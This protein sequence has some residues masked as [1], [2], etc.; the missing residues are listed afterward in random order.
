MTRNAK[1]SDAEEDSK[2][3][4]TN[5]SKQFLIF[6]PPMV[7]TLHLKRFQQTLMGCRKLNKHVVFPLVLDLAPFCSST[8]LAFNH[9]QLNQNKVN[10]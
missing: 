4:Y 3:V 1:N 5:A 10:F 9:L 6:Y 8:S 2:P 7:L